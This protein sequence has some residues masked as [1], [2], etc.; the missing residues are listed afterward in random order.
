LSSWLGLAPMRPSF[1]WQTFGWAMACHGE[2]GKKNTWTG[3]LCQ[4]R[5]HQHKILKPVPFTVGKSHEW[6]IG[7]Q[8]N[9]RTPTSQ[10]RS[11]S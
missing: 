1:A 5:Q 7:D 10:R 4:R 11:R 3:L 6:I 2:W 9:L 8:T